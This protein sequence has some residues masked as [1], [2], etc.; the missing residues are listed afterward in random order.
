MKMLCEM[1]DEQ[2]CDGQHEIPETA[3]AICFVHQELLCVDCLI[4]KK[5]SECKLK[6]INKLSSSENQLIEVLKIKKCLAERK[7]LVT[8]HKKSV[9]E[10]IDTLKS[11]I[12]YHAQELILRVQEH[13]ANTIRDLNDKSKLLVVT[14]DD[15]MEKILDLENDI[16]VVTKC[17]SAEDGNIKQSEVLR[18]KDKLENIVIMKDNTVLSRY[19]KK[20]F[21]SSLDTNELGTVEILDA[22]NMLDIKDVQT[23]KQFESES[24]EYNLGSEETTDLNAEE[25]VYVMTVPSNGKENH[26]KNRSLLESE[27]NKEEWQKCTSPWEKDISKTQETPN[28]EQG[29]PP[30][31][32][33]V[34]LENNQIVIHE[35]SEKAKLSTASFTHLLVTDHNELVLF[36]QYTHGLIVC[37]FSGE[38]KMKHALLKAPL[39]ITQYENNSF[40]ILNCK[41]FTIQIFCVEN[42]H[43]AT[44]DMDFLI[45]VSKAFHVLG[46]AYDNNRKQ[47]AL[48]GIERDEGLLFLIRATD[49]EMSYEIRRF[50]V[51]SVQQQC[52]PGDYQT[53]YDFER[54]CVYILNKSHK[55]IKCFLFAKNKF[56]WKIACNDASFVP[57]QL[58]FDQQN[59]YITSKEN[60]TVFSKNSGECKTTH[61]ACI[62]EL[63]AICLMK[64][65]HIAIVSCNSSDPQTSMT[66]E[67]VALP[68]C[69]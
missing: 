55:T 61:N 4:N 14:D 9:R 26:I 24:F 66:L 64:H 54:N 11:R 68:A 43:L 38:I 27:K 35:K 23:K 56:G 48:H 40:A 2:L 7:R 42:E 29:F 6:R 32:G 60:V 10:E 34:G 59:L 15:E 21:L 47:F 39:K 33:F 8:R 53:Q 18:L 22:D 44:S 58:V 63:K 1:K 20:L 28:K 51:S 41:D 5:Q 52:R 62:G 17:F 16:S 45:P 69:D 36:D 3:V 30:F 57:D 12:K 37:N 49:N 19:T 67:C 13:E 65:H 25:D 46:F 50:H 31:F